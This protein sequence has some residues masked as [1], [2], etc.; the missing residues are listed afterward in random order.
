VVCLVE[1]LSTGLLVKGVL[2]KEFHAQPLHDAWRAGV[3]TLERSPGL[4]ARNV[5]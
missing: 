2:G 3:D 1:R 4:F 5:M